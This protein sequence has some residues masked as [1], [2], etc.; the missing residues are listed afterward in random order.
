[1][2]T[3]LIGKHTH[4]ELLCKHRHV[5][6]AW[7]TMKNHSDDKNEEVFSGS[8]EQLHGSTMMPTAFAGPPWSPQSGLPWFKV[9]MPKPA[10]G[11]AD[12]ERPPP[13][14]M[15]SC[16]F[17][18]I[19]GTVGGTAVISRVPS[20]FRACYTGDASSVLV[21]VRSACWAKGSGAIGPFCCGEFPTGGIV[22]LG[23]RL[24]VCLV[25]IAFF[26]RLL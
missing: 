16:G 25:Q 26:L 13:N 14:A 19:M 21:I 23:F 10:P 11:A 9:W 4:P 8:R 24:G 17:K 7:D 3:S 12:A 6:V 15:D 1:M 22:R 5:M 18:L 2:F 20:C